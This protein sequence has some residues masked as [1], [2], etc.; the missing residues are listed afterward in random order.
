MDPLQ[1]GKTIPAEKIPDLD[2]KASGMQTWFELGWCGFTLWASSVDVWFI[3]WL[4]A[5]GM[6]DA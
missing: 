1:V 5:D 2:K 6:E 4:L 3:D